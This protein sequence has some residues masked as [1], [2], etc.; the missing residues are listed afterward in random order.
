MFVPVGVRDQGRVIKVEKFVGVDRSVE[1]QSSE[2]LVG[3]IPVSCVTWGP[4][5][6]SLNIFTFKRN[7]IHGLLYF[8]LNHYFY[9]YELLL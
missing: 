5:Q 3:P 4:C 6:L 1:G 7:N 9:F 2:M 8:Q